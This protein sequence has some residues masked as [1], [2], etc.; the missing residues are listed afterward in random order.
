[1]SYFRDIRQA[2]VQSHANNIIDD[3]EFVLL[4]DLNTSNNLD[5]P[6][7]NYQ[8]FDLDRLTAKECWS[9]FRFRKD[10]IYDLQNIFR[11]PDE[12]HTYNRMKID[13][14]EALCIFLHKF[15]YTCRY[16]DMIPRFARAVPELSVISNHV[17]DHLYS[18]F[19][20]KLTS[21]AQ[22]WLRPHC[23]EQF[24]ETI[25]S[26]GAALD[27]CFRFVDGTVR[28]ICRPETNQRVV[29]NGHKKI[30][31]LKFQSVVTP[32]GLIANL[33][34][35]VE[36]RRHDSGMLADSNLLTQLGIFALNTNGDNLCIYGDP[37]YP[38][39]VSLQ[40][41]FRN[42]VL[43]PQQKAFN[44]SMSKVN[45]IYEQLLL[46]SARC[47]EAPLF[48]FISSRR[49]SNSVSSATTIP[50]ALARYDSCFLNFPIKG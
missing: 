22:A 12:V 37:A 31:S 3:E 29:Y 39:R 4:Y 35:P 20:I 13:G 25:H 48:S 21:F 27:N 7:W 23:L 2:L 11:I 50:E 49:T 44:K 33:Y 43:T 30:H 46:L 8:P 42:P 16:S 28:P 9:E 17:L 1:L 36:G 32:N 34:G 38:L 19:N 26:K 41:P 14:V 40:A 5:Y 15:A 24:C 47:T 18:N 6:Y 45:Q 10:D